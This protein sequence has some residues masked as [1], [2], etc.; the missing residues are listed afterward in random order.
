MRTLFVGCQNQMNAA[1]TNNKLYR[2]S[3]E[4]TNNVSKS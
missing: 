3:E 4:N 2:K 1:R